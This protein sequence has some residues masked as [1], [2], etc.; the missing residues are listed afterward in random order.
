MHQWLIKVGKAHTTSEEHQ[1]VQAWHQ[2]VNEA[3]TTKPKGLYKWMKEDVQTSVVMLEREDHTM[4]G[5]IQEMDQLI[6]LH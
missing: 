5:I 6:H 2:W 1:R 3:W 4:T